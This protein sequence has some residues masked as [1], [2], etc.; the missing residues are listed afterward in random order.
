MSLKLSKAYVVL[1]KINWKS[2]SWIALRLLWNFYHSQSARVCVQ[3]T[4]QV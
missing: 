2:L 1:T 3:G 4:E